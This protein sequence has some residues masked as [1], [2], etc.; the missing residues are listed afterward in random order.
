VKTFQG[1]RSPFLG[2]LLATLLLVP[3]LVSTP[4]AAQLKPPGSNNGGM[5]GG[6]DLNGLG[7]SSGVSGGF[8]SGSRSNSGGGFGSGL[9]NSYSGGSSGSGMGGNGGMG[10][11][12]TSG[13]GGMPGMGSSGQG[14]AGSVGGMGVGRA[15]TVSGSGAKPAHGLK[16]IKVPPAPVV[17]NKYTDYNW[18][19]STT[20]NTSTLYAPSWDAPQADYTWGATPQ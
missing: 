19:A 4:A 2:A 10:G 14:T 6:S 20:S 1:R 9:G 16:K 5:T 7:S 15:G 18:G 11:S 3:W 8:G 12:S 17:P 13:G